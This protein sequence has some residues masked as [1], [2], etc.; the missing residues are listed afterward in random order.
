VHLSICNV[1]PHQS[2]D[3]T[4]DLRGMT[5]STAS[6]R[7]LTAD[8]MQAHNTFDTP[9][10]VQPATFGCPAPQDNRLT[11]ALPPMSVVVLALS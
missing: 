5:L 8:Q 9:A 1:N 3:V 7:V 10:A 4:C 2:A 6:G 11:I